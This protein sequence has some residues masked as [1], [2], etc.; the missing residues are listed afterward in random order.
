[1]SESGLYDSTATLVITYKPLI[2]RNYAYKFYCNSRD[3]TLPLLC[4]TLSL[5]V[6]DLLQYVLSG[7][8]YTPPPPPHP[9]K[10]KQTHRSTKHVHS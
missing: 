4:T 6:E 3:N 5:I 10:F 9:P 1:M 7:P 2:F 8:D